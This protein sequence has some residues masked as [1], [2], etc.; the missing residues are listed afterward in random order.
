MAQNA[1]LGPLYEKKRQLEAEIAALASVR[2]TA[3][4]ET[5]EAAERLL[6]PN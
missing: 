2:D 1:V 3:D 5:R 6:I 4:R